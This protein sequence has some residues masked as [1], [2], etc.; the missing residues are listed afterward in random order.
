MRARQRVIA[1]RGFYINLA[2]FFLVNLTLTLLSLGTGGPLWFWWI[3]VIW[4]IGLLIH[5][6]GVF[7]WSVFFGRNWEE[8]KI[9]EYMD[10]EKRQSR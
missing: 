8:T 7:S 1:L 5:A 3:T 10:E 4:G 9:R 6:Y 2:L